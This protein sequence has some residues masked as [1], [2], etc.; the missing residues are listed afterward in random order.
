MNVGSVD[1]GCSPV[2]QNVLGHHL[3]SK[4]KGF[5]GS[6]GGFTHGFIAAFAVRFPASWVGERCRANSEGWQVMIVSEIG[7]KTFFIAAIMVRP[8]PQRTCFGACADLT[9]HLVSGH[10]A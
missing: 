1:Q 8:V 10:A 9:V 4:L 5:I 2:T 6:P 7:D 3:S